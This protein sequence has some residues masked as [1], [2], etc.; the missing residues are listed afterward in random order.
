MGTPFAM[1][2]DQGFM[3]SLSRSFMDDQLE[4]SG[5]TFYN[6]DMNSFMLGGKFEYSLGESWTVHLGLTQFY[7]NEN[8]P[9]DP[10]NDLESFSH[11][12]ISLKYN[13]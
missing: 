2:V 1:L 8:E 6:L 12:Q 10:F 5:N 9:E 4:L 7:G 11:V 3:F 13:F